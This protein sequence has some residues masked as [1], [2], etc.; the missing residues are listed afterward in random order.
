LGYDPHSTFFWVPKRLANIWLKKSNKKK[1]R[2][3]SAVAKCHD[4]EV[5]NFILD[6][7]MPIVA[8]APKDV[9]GES[10]DMGESCPRPARPKA[11]MNG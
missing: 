11:V 3:Q 6:A 2:N 4:V 10:G 9:V 7:T 1:R 8:M 5:G